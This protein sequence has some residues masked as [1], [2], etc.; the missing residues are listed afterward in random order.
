MSKTSSNLIFSKWYIVSRVETLFCWRNLTFKSLWYKLSYI[1]LRWKVNIF[2]FNCIA[3]LS[4]IKGEM[5]TTIGRSICSLYL[6]WRVYKHN[7]LHH[8]H[9]H[10][11]LRIAFFCVKSWF[12]NCN[13]FFFILVRL[14]GFLNF[15]ENRRSS[16]ATSLVTYC[17]SV[18]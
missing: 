8:R 15:Y 1:V 10:L 7:A 2:L 13:K 3:K 6:L 11:S 5:T 14:R 17:C 12:G 16:M 18:L 9:P 4:C